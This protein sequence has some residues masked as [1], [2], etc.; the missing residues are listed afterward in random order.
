MAI[1]WAVAASRA[2]AIDLVALTTAAGNV[3]SD[4]TYA[5]AW[6]ALQAAG[7]HAPAST[8]DAAAGAGSG[9]DG[10]KTSW[11]CPPVGRGALEELESDGFMGGD[12]LGGLSANFPPPPVAFEDAEASDTLLV[13][14]L[15]AAPDRTV[16]VVCLGPLT[17]LA[18]A[19]RLNPGILRRAKEVVVMAGAFSVS[20][21]ITPD[22][23]FNVLMNP[24][25]Y[26]DTLAAVDV[27]FL[28]LD[29]T[30][31][32]KVGVPEIERLTAF[33]ASAITSSGGAG[34][35]ATV[36]AA[37]AVATP[38]EKL[39]GLVEGLW[40]FMVHQ[41]L[42][43]KQS[44]GKEVMLLHDGGA[45]GYVLYPS[46]FLL[47]RG[48]VRV[49]CSP[50]GHP[51]RGRTSVDARLTF[52]AAP[53]GWVALRVEAPSAVAAFIEDMQSLVEQLP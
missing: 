34:F 13:R 43:F 27:T 14:T 28:P 8:T 20:G 53:N 18:A 44:A 51:S 3:A 21:N 23:E 47:R 19:E 25:S 5:A 42:N 52:G 46:L 30:N 39:L 50:A 48:A 12:G 6:T 33:G 16:T 31:E 17:N 22:A 9:T 38:A 15:L 40:R 10:G 37:T 7:C 11:A 24:E 4:L 41:T 45:V 1:L 29:V 49:D 32:L 26:R 2:G 36:R 35:A